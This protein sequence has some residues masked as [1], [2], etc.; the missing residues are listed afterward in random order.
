MN[1]PTGPA[2]P[3]GATGATPT[4]TVAATNTGEPGTE[5]SVTA[6]DTGTGV[7]LTFTIPRGNPGGN[8]TENNALL[9]YNDSQTVTAGSPVIFA[10]R[11]FNPGTGSSIS[12]SGTTGVTLEAGKYLVTFVSDAGVT[13]AGSIAATLQLDGTPVSNAVE[14]SLAQSG[15]ATERITLNAIVTST[16]GQTLTV[17]NNGSDE[18]THANTALTLVQLS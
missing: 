1:A 8:I 13:G 14:T 12:A 6:A 16:G 10:D 11:T 7:A 17:V 5:A 15:A 9:T 2:G 3:A 18:N 4:V